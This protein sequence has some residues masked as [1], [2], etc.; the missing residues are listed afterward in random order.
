MTD[1]CAH[2]AAGAVCEACA[3]RGHSICAA[4]EP[5]EL[6]ALERISQSMTY[7]ARDT[8]FAQ[9]EAA[10]LVFTVTAGA[11]RLSNVSPDG[12]RQILGFALPGDFLGLAPNEL[13]PY[14]AEAVGAV[15]ACRFTRGAHEALVAEKPHLLR[16]LHDYATHELTLAQEQIVLLGR[17]TAAERVAAFLLALR[18]RWAALNGAPSVTVPLPMGRQDIADYLGLTIETVSRM[19]Q[20]FARARLLAIVPDGVRLLDPAALEA[21]A[22]GGPVQAARSPNVATTGRLSGA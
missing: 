4:L 6:V 16:R 17:R 3:V 11:V 13:Y 7:A 22:D 5:E 8:L 10:A 9:G 20:K 14:S 12:R 15:S 21:V 19:F 2:R 1:L 18:Q